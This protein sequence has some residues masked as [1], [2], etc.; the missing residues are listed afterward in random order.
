MRVLVLIFFFLFGS[1]LFAQDDKSIVLMDTDN[2]WR[3]EAFRFPKPFAPEVD[4][5]GVATFDLRRVGLRLI[6][7]CFGLMPSYGR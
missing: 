5:H 7:H 1:L 4:F 3:K 2:T 6:A